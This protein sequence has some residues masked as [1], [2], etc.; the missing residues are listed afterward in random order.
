MPHGNFPKFSGGNS[1]AGK[2]PGFPESLPNK[3]FPVEKCTG[4]SYN[5]ITKPTPFR[6]TVSAPVINK[7]KKNKIINVVRC[8]IYE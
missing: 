5:V 4:L 7:Y 1:P 2:F 8:Y 6:K 3:F